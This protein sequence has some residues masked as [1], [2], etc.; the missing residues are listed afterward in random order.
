MGDRVVIMADIVTRALRKLK[1]LGHPAPVNVIFSQVG[2]SGFRKKITA[3]RSWQVSMLDSLTSDGILTKQIHGD[4]PVY[5]VKDIDA[6]TESISMFASADRRQLYDLF[7][8]SSGPPPSS[9]KYGDTVFI[10][11][12]AVRQLDRQLGPVKTEIVFDPRPSLDMKVDPPVVGKSGLPVLVPQKLIDEVREKSD[13]KR[14]VIVARPQPKEHDEDEDVIDDVVKP[15]VETVHDRIQ[16]ERSD[17]KIVATPVVDDVELSTVSSVPVIQPTYGENKYTTNFHEASMEE[18]LPRKP[19]PLPLS[20]VTAPEPPPSAAPSST[21]NVKPSPKPLASD[22][23]ML[24]PLE[25]R[26]VQAVEDILLQVSG[27]KWYRSAEFIQTGDGINREWKF[28]ILRNLVDVGVL[29]RKGERR[30]TIYRGVPARINE[31][32]DDTEWLLRMVAPKAVTRASV[33]TD[34]QSDAENEE[35]GIVLNEELQSALLEIQVE[36]PKAEQSSEEKLLTDA[37]ARMHQLYEVLEYHHERLN[38][39]ESK[40]DEILQH[41]RETKK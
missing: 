36:E 23:P 40:M 4:R 20:V 31:L 30:N 12:V 37:I 6:L 41:L 28:Q 1:S 10:D 9:R 29:E 34:I 24:T 13:V 2:N 5:M 16:K 7:G 27:V 17:A 39:L 14:R 15:H 33:V 21:S 18:P 22:H 38:T 3:D 25:R 19:D 35:E 32:L 11:P 8:N 26:R